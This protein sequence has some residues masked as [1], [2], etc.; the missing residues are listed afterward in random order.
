LNILSLLRYATLAILLGASPALAKKANESGQTPPDVTGVSDGCV[1]HEASFKRQGD[2]ALFVIDLK[3]ICETRF[4]CRVSAYLT[5]SHGPQQ[6]KTVLVLAPQSRGKAAEKSSVTPMREY[7]G[8]ASVSHVCK[9][10]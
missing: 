3:N 10:A 9:K 8:A 7:G 5:T 2:K 4:R 6:I 1:S